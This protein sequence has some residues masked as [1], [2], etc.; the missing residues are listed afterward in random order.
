MMLNPQTVHTKNFG[1]EGG[2]DEEVRA[3]NYEPEGL[4]RL[5]TRDPFDEPMMLNPPAVHTKNFGNDGGG[6]RQEDN[7]EPE[8]LHRLTTRDPFDEP[9]MFNLSVVQTVPILLPD[10]TAPASQS[11]GFVA[12]TAT[13]A[14]SLEASS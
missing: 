2:G 8:G 7:Y 3:D 14:N 10:Q 12:N 4:H 1:N 6:E 13:K 11:N 9:T 5:T